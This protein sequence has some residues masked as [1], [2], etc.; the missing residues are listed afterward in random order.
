MLG[1]VTPSKR[2]HFNCWSLNSWTEATSAGTVRS[3]I[4]MGTYRISVPSALYS[5]PSWEAKQGLFSATVME[6]MTQGETGVVP[7]ELGSRSH[8]RTESG[9]VKLSHW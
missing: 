8:F 7:Q 3:V 5:T 4:V 9:R 1:G 2:R 6:P